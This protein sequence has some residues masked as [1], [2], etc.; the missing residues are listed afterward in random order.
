M[1]RSTALAAVAGL[2]LVGVLVG[3]LGTH[4]FYLRQLRQPGGMATLGN[5]FLAAGLDRR[6]D[7]TAEQRRQVDAILA[8]A[9]R[10]A[11][12]VRR[13]MMPRVVEILDRS[14]HRLSAVLTPEQRQE[15]E[16]FRR[17]RGDRVRRLLLGL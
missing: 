5:R 6:L 14:H 17:Q 1:K 10:E 11:R 15:L 8:D 7:L 2:F 9:A 12:E 13:E 3:I 16:R 4:L